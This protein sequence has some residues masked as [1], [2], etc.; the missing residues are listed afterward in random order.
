MILEFK[1]V[2]KTAGKDAVQNAL[3]QALEQ[4][5]EKK[6]ETELIARGIPNEQ[7]RKYGFVFRGKEVWIGAKF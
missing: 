4:I 7:I 5:Q 6:Y 1:A 3:R 2:D